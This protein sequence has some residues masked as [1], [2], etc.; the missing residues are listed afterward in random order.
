VL[1]LISHGINVLIAGTVGILLF[2][3][4]DRFKEIYG[5]ETVARRILSCVYLSIALTSAY[6]LAFSEQMLSIALVLFP[7]QIVYK[8]LTY[9]VIEDKKNPVLW[10]NLG[11][12]LIHGSTLFLTLKPSF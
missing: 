7:L 6:A 3:D 8:L 4:H 10:F 12:S 5:K 2:A 9:F 11:I 1:L